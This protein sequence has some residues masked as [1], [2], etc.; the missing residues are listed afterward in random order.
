MSQSVKSVLDTNS[1]EHAKL[2]SRYLATQLAL[3][4]ALDAAIQ[5]TTTREQFN[6][7]LYPDKRVIELCKWMVEYATQAEVFLNLPVK[8]E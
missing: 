6:T 7:R 5:R 4:Y 1:T 2:R 8:E 3:K